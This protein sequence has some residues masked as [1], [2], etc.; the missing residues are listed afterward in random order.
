MS[1]REWNEG[2][3]LDLKSTE[4][5]DAGWDEDEVIDLHP[6]ARQSEPTD[7]D[8]GHPEADEPGDGW[9]KSTHMTT[10]SGGDLDVAEPP[11]GSD[12]ASLEQV[13]DPDHGWDDQPPTLRELTEAPDVETARDKVVEAYGGADADQ[14]RRVV[15]AQIAAFEG[16]LDGAGAEESTRDAVDRA[17]SDTPTAAQTDHGTPELTDEQECVDPHEA[18]DI[19]AARSQDHEAHEGPPNQGRVID[20]QIAAFEAHLDG[21]EAEESTRNAVHRAEVERPA[22]EAVPREVVERA[23]VVEAVKPPTDAR[24][25]HSEGQSALV[26]R[27]AREMVSLEKSETPLAEN[28]VAARSTENRIALADDVPAIELKPTYDGYLDVVMHGDRTGTQADINGNRIDFSLPETA[29]MIESSP[30]WDHRPIRLLSCSVGQDRYAQELADRLRVPVYA[31]D[32]LLVVAHDGTTSVM[33]ADGTT[34]AGWR[35]FEPQQD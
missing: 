30:S 21:A 29:G 11:E 27:E 8:D 12:V 23:D 33:S 20:A 9:S 17:H 15:D 6:D 28:V 32:G 24:V 18:P 22:A 13:D 3:V 34:S 1:Q 31:P 2:D 26:E 14:E 5:N 4:P 16:H 10:S 19:S 35:R 7:A 25:E